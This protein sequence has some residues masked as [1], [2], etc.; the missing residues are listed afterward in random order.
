MIYSILVFFFIEDSAMFNAV[1]LRRDQLLA[2]E[3][4]TGAGKTAVTPFEIA[5]RSGKA[6]LVICFS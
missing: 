5:Y 6:V 3:M 2:I 1:D 4:P